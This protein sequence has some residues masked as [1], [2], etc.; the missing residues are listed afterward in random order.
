MFRRRLLSSALTLSMFVGACDMSALYP[1]VSQSLG[2]NP[3]GL[4][5]ISV[6]LSEPEEPIGDPPG[7]TTDPPGTS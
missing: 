6:L 1:G 5:K 2:V 7:G 4:G 3:F